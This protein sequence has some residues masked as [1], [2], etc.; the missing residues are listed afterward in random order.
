M[1]LFYK[2]NFAVLDF[3]TYNYNNTYQVKKIFNKFP[4]ITG[5]IRI[6]FLPEISELTTLLAGISHRLPNRFFKP[7][8]AKRLI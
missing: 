3:E 7:Y 5:K 6:N 2:H 1:C 8:R 4:E